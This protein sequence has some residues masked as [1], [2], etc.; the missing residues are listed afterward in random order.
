MVDTT[1]Q[2]AAVLKH[3]A[4]TCLYRSN[5]NSIQAIRYRA[6]DTCLR[7]RVRHQDGSSR[8]EYGLC[9]QKYRCQRPGKPR[10]RVVTVHPQSTTPRGS[11][12]EV[13]TCARTCSYCTEPAHASSSSCRTRRASAPTRCVLSCSLCLNGDMP[14]EPSSWGARLTA[15]PCMS[16]F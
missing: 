12:S 5:I 16:P 10:G 9:R 3:A 1:L 7:T 13:C 14:S 4:S 8:F 6:V 2:A 11:R 15:E